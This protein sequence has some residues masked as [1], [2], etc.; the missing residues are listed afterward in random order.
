MQNEPMALASPPELLVPHTLR[1]LGHASPR[2][3]AALRS[4]DPAAVE[5][6]LEDDRA[7]GLVTRSEVGA[8]TTWHLTDRGRAKGEADLSAEL[9]RSGGRRTVTEAHA[10]FL[11]LN[12]RIGTVMTQWQLQ[13]TATDRLAANE[14]R[15][16]AYDD[17]V[18]RRLARL[19]RDLRQVTDRLSS[20]LQRFDLHQPRIDTALRRVQAGEDSW[21]DSP[22][23]PSM[24]IVWIQLH[25]DLLAT[26]GIARGEDDS[27]S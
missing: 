20:V 26:L 14:H 8:T 6:Q 27:G 7:L 4:L 2:R 3:I 24:N 5:T 10:A 9:D 15:D 12:R 21:V 19:G 1:V 22:E 11:V 25:E 17:A 23:V 13:P 16:A 18:I